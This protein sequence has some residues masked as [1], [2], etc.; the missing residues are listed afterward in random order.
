MQENNE[1][2]SNVNDAKKLNAC[3]AFLC[4]QD[5]DNQGCVDDTSVIEKLAERI[6]KTPAYTDPSETED[7]IKQSIKLIEE[8]LK[9]QGV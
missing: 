3:I 7:F 8:Y 9:E 6:S 5:L 1:V 2:V 4:L